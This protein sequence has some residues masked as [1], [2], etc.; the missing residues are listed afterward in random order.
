MGFGRSG[1]A[2]AAVSAGLAA[3]QDDLVSCRRYLPH[4]VLRRSRRDDRADFHTLGN[5]AR[6]I[7]FVHLSGRQTDLIAIRA[8]SCRRC[9]HQLPLRQLTRQRVRDRCQ[10]ISG[11]GHTH[12]AVNIASA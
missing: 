9:R 2:A 11:S 7:D 10:R 12:R 1:R 5:I 3:E 8:V 6:M 4:H